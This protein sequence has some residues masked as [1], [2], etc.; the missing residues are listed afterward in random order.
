MDKMVIIPDSF[1][2]TMSSKQVGKIIAQQAAS[3]WPD[4][5]IIQIP[6]ADGGEGTVDALLE[7]L[8][9]RKKSVWVQGPWGD[10]IES[11]YG[12]C[13]NTALIEMAAAAGLPLTGEKRDPGKTTTFG[14]G[15][16]IFAAL[17]AGAQTIILGLGGSAT[18]DGGTGA[19]TALG[20]RFMDA[21]QQP[22][23]PVGDTLEKIQCIDF[24]EVDPRLSHTEIL[25]MCDIKNSL[26][27]ADGAAAVFGPQKGADA[28]QVAKLD[29]GLK[30]LA[31]VI[32]KQRERDVLELPGGGAAGGM[33]AGIAA[34]FDA[35]LVPGIETILDLVN[36]D[37]LLNG[38]T[39]VVTGEGR[40]DA[41][42]S[43]GK[44]ISGVVKRAK[45]AKVPVVAIGGDIGEGAEQLYR[46]GLTAMFSINQRA[47][48]FEIAKLCAQK[49]L[50]TTARNVFVLIHALEDKSQEELSVSE[51]GDDTLNYNMYI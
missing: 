33:G 27:G 15:Q 47:I 31:E 30:H 32:Q 45:K 48:P 19:A 18:N 29:A 5:Q 2:G 36:F 7:V 13:G 28:Q 10:K 6:V 24:S 1:K 16:L 23:I 21:K 4:A 34:F 46:L 37:E 20:I 11:F 44:V 40:I 26:C 3:I 51:V 39:L 49:D 35:K 9:G 50:Q 43:Q 25:A 41:Q 38:C 12:M 14:V 8:P 17:D 42:S 22:F